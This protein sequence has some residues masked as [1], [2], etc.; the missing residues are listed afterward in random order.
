MRNKC[1]IR[2]PRQLSPYEKGQ[3]LAYA[4]M[5][6]CSQL[7]LP[8]GRVGKPSEVLEGLLCHQM[9]PFSAGT[10]CPLLTCRCFVLSAA[11]HRQ[12][13]SWPPPGMPCPARHATNIPS[14]SMFS[15]RYPRHP[16]ISRGFK[17][18][19]TWRVQIWVIELD[20]SHVK[21]RSEECKHSLHSTDPMCTY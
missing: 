20:V 21:C 15:W 14:H 1:R 18:Q 10:R 8:Y 6:A 19:V 5:T 9:C 4:R 17:E 2:E 12:R 7:G 16:H 13:W 11:C 3:A